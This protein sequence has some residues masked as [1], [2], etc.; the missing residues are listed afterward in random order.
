MLSYR[1]T[2]IMEN[3]YIPIKR[4]DKLSGQVAGQIQDLIL[5]KKIKPGERLPT[6]RELGDMFQ[7]SRTVIREAIRT[8]EARG[9]ITSQTGSGNY[10]RAVQGEDVVNSLGMYL[11]SQDSSYTVESIME[12][13]RVLELQ[14][15]KLAAE[16]ATDDDI[17]RLELIVEQMNQSKNDIDS[18]SKWDLEF[19]LALAHACDNY[20]FNI[21]IEPLSEP[22][23]ELMWTGSTIPGAIDDACQFHR[24][25]LEALK[26]KDVDLAV[27]VMQ[28]HLDQS[29]RVAVEGLKHRKK[30][31]NEE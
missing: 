4:Q 23:F 28:T 2:N 11:S 30:E 22:L 17:D 20:L 1:H 8:L 14:V 5:S 10:V 19:H 25:I 13:R 29:Q 12:V 15:V 9:L 18:F 16:R 6:E 31:S 3:S 26:L 7:V 27:N 24:D 21:L